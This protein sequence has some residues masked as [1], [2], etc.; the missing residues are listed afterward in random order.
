MIGAYLANLVRYGRIDPVEYYVCDEYRVVYVENAKVACTAIKQVLYPDV[1]AAAL[2]TDAFHAALRDRAD[3]SVPRH[4][5]DYL[6]FSFFR[7]PAERLA[8]AWRDKIR[9]AGAKGE[10]SIFHT[11][12][13]RA[14]F[15][16][17]AGIDP[18][19]PGLGLGDFAQAVARLPDPLRDR[20]IAS[21]A[22]IHA[23]VTA[24]AR[25]FV[26]HYERFSDDWAAIR[27]RSEL[28]EPTRL[29]ATHASPEAASDGTAAPHIARAYRADF[30]ALGYAMP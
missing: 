17:F 13:H 26:G 4:A 14:V 12:F 30:A 23:A 11:R 15:G 29:N 22:P 6:R 7:H 5:R 16:A 10:P 27:Q 8:S 18:A 9:D 20:H 3:Y 28:P 1:D 19:R 21:Q 25:H 24:G 2:G